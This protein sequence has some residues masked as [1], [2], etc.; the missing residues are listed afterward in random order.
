MGNR[1]TILMP[2]TEPACSGH[3]VGLYGE[4]NMGPESVYAYLDYAREVGL[5]GGSC[6]AARLCQI[7]CNFLGGTVYVGCFVADMAEPWRWCSMAEDGGSFILTA[8]DPGA[9]GLWRVARRVFWRNELIEYS[10][11]QIAFEEADAR[12]HPCWMGDH[13]ILDEIREKNAAYF[14]PAR[15]LKAA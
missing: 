8:S 6:G 10:P 3:A 9:P 4:W 15:L 13:T 2:E 5:R 1:G 7:I 12:R 14:T 11:E